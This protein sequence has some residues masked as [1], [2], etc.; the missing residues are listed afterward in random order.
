MLR[1][2]AS[3]PLRGP[4]GAAGRDIVR[5]AEL[6]LDRAATPGVELVILDAWGEDRDARA[7][8][9]ARR[10]AAD[11]DAVAYLG[12]FH[13]SQVESTAPVLAAARLLQV[14]PG[15]TYAGLGG[16]TLVR[17]MPD[18]RALARGIAGWVAGAGLR[19][20]LVVHDHD[21]GYGVPVG[22]MCL[23]A[24]REAGLDAHGRPVWDHD[25]P[26]A[27]DLAG[28]D[29]VLYA[30]VA[31]PGAAALWGNL[32]RH[33]PARWLLATD[34]LAVDRFARE[35]D[36]GAAER[37]R[38]FTSQRAPWGFYG[39]E[40]AALILDAIAEAGG[41]R[42]G[43]VA[44]ARGARDRESILGRY[45]IDPDGLTTAPADGVLAVVAGEIVRERAP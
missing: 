12:D 20:V 15:A 28:A 41:E 26:I 9:N 44:A 33:D 2:F 4:A 5:G 34:G 25:E 14:A 37:T 24:L 40:A 18:D 8:A 23:R 36:A 1:I 21:E 6:A 27:D 45:S 7:V 13:S 35:L 3:M 42:A 30:G 17:L 19:G 11:A 43:V 29:A 39:Y 31:G 22:G 32:H 10:A 16:P 38:L